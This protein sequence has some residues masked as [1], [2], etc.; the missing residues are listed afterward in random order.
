MHIHRYIEI[1]APLDVTHDLLGEQPPF[2]GERLGEFWRWHDELWSIRQSSFDDGRILWHGTCPA[3]PQAS[4]L[5]SVTP[6]D[7]LVAT[8]LQLH[9]AVTFPG[10]QWHPLNNRRR[11]RQVAA[12]LDAALDA[13]CRRAQERAPRPVASHA[14]PDDPEQ[15]ADALQA[16]HPATVAAFREMAALPGLLA[17]AQLDRRWQA[18]EA[19]AF[20]ADV[21][22][23]VSALP[24][25]LADFDLIYAGGGLGALHAA[26]MVCCYGY[27][28]LLFDRGEVGCAHREWNISDQ[29]LRALVRIGLFTQAELERVIMRRYRDGIVHFWPEQS[30]VRPV[31]LHLPQVLNVALDAAGLLQMTRAKIEAAGGIVLDRR[32]FKRVCVQTPGR[33]VVELEREDG[34]LECFGARVLLDGMGATS[35][36][37]LRRFAGQPFAGVCPTVGTVVEGLE[38]GPALDQHHPDVGDILVSIA[39]TQRGRQLIWE[40]FAGRGDEL[41]VYVFYY[42]LLQKRDPRTKRENQDAQRAPGTKNQEPNEKAKTPKGYP[43]P[44]TRE[45]KTKEPVQRAE[46]THSLLDLFEDYFRLLPTYKRPGPQFRHIKPVYGF[47]PARHTQRR[48]TVPLLPGVLPI[49]D[50]SAQQSPLTFCGFGSHVRNLDRTT[51]LLDHALRRDLLAPQHLGQISAYQANVALNWVLSRFMQP[52]RSPNDVNRLQNIFARVLNEIGVDV[53]VRFFQ[54]QMTWRDYGRILNHTL[55]IYKPIIPTT[56]AVLGPRDT[57]RWVGDWLRFSAAAATATIGRGL[58]DAALD[59]LTKRLDRA[60]PGLAFRLAARRAEWRVMGWDRS[61][62]VGRV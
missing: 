17:V 56:L 46:P 53:A 33:V 13:L 22:Q 11:E 51:A 39:D 2:D 10:N 35:P 5:L 60:A 45:G 14:L 23:Q 54:D 55:A 30:A 29:E 1:P 18:T 43:E 62:P 38:Q 25:T 4:F 19:G 24:E 20:A 37:A 59:A 21:H 3:L 36:L 26:V 34:A 49:G 42:D 27:R 44:S 61:A 58:G 32:S 40:G 52:W 47:I 28:V 6:H 48:L 7:A 8:Y 12:A 50:S 16:T 9:L 31:E 57:I 41:T 15:L